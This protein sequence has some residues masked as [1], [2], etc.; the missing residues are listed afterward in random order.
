MLETRTILPLLLLSLCVGQAQAQPGPASQPASTPAPQPASAA[1]SQPVTRPVGPASPALPVRASDPLLAPTTS[2]AGWPADASASEALVDS[3]SLRNT[4]AGLT[5]ILT[6]VGMV[7]A[8]IGLG[9]LDPC[10]RTYCEPDDRKASLFAVGAGV[11][12]SSVGLSVGIPIWVVGQNR[13]ERYS[14]SPAQ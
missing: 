2:S 1:A 3:R 9:T 6:A 5:L 12:L 4:G 10:T 8:A 14:P 11:F 13:I 7:V